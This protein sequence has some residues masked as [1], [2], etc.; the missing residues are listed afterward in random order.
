[1]YLIVSA[2]PLGFFFLAYCIAPEVTEEMA[3]F[4][5]EWLAW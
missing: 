4:D 3:I 2:F 5:E 1:M